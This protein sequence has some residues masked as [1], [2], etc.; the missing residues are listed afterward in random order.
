[1][2]FKSYGDFSL[3]F[4]IVYYVL[5][6]DYPVYMD[7]NQEINLAIYREFNREGIEFA[8]PTQTLY[9]KQEAP[10]IPGEKP[11]LKKNRKK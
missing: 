3:D 9:L 11:K 10:K 6:R 2:H 5:S 8:F 1:M 7:T 4:E